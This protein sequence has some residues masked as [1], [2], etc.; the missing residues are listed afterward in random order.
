MEY[1]INIDLRPCEPA[2][3]N[4]VP[5]FRIL[6]AK[7]AEVPDWAYSKNLIHQSRKAQ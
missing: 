1:G 4:V 2:K 6:E 5:L 3:S 7:P